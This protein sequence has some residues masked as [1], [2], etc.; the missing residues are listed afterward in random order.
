MTEEL[1]DEIIT[2]VIKVERHFAFDKKALKTARKQ[3]VR[4]KVEDLVNQSLKKES[5]EDND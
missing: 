5:Q 1:V 3:E 4:K 2:E